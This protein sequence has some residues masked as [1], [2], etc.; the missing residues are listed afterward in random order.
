MCGI[1]GAIGIDSRDDGAAVLSRMLRSIY[2][3]GPDEEGALVLPR[4]AA[5]TRR[6][7][8][9]DLAGGSQP[10]WNEARTLAINFNGEIYNYRQLRAE[11]LAAG[12]KFRTQSDTE[13]I[14]HAFEE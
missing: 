8:I 3:R 2:H 10:I 1:C 9:I 5:G 6:L 4:Y 14:I 11:L 13:V 12:H 7:S